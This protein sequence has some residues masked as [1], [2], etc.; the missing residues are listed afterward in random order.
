MPIVAAS[1]KKKMETRILNEL[2]AAFASDGAASP[3]AQKKWE[4]IAKAVAASAEDICAMLLTE[5][6]VAPGIPVATSGGPGATT[7]PGKLL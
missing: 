4:A 7:S 5:A 1:L 3:D 6:Q 2:K